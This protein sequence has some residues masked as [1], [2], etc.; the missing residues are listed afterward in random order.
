M[1]V[2]PG[3]VKKE[4][5]AFKN[6]KF[7]NYLFGDDQ[8]S[9]MTHFSGADDDATDEGPEDVFQVP[10]KTG[11]QKCLSDAKEIWSKHCTN[12][13]LPGKLQ[14]AVRCKASWRHDFFEIAN[15]RDTMQT[16]FDEHKTR[17]FVRFAYDLGQQLNK[18][19]D[20]ATE[21]WKTFCAPKFT[22]PGEKFWSPSEDF[23]AGPDCLFDSTLLESTEVSKYSAAVQ[24]H[25]QELLKYKDHH[26]FFLPFA[27]I[28]KNG[29]FFDVSVDAVN[30]TG[31]QK[32]VFVPGKIEG[33]VAAKPLN[34]RYAELD[35]LV[36]QY[37][38]TKTIKGK[39]P[40]E[41]DYDSQ[42]PLTTEDC[43]DHLAPFRNIMSKV[44]TVPTLLEGYPQKTVDMVRL[45]IMSYGYE[46]INKALETSVMENPAAAEKS[47]T[48][49]Y[50]LVQA[51]VPNLFS[52]VL[53]LYSRYV[54]NLNGHNGQ[55]A[56]ERLIEA[57]EIMSTNGF[58]WHGLK[59]VTV[60]YEDVEKGKRTR[61]QLKQ[62][63]IA[64]N[65][66]DR[67]QRDQEQIAILAKIQHGTD[68]AFTN[69]HW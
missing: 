35:S 41:F 34:E 24:K 22:F 66:N 36:G 68:E 48:T 43:A 10:E 38:E 18:I 60:P 46:Y 56:I 44:E 20:T 6:T 26:P 47:A 21:S 53:E 52:N 32:F 33:A 19:Q 13:F 5:K 1:K 61:Y 29:Q 7:T 67:F 27:N 57:F 30:G 28:L 4:V 12:M 25:V 37:F 51:N 64:N 63:L 16:C 55:K 2:V 3:V 69:G 62:R 23:V 42:L 40:N 50:F 58:G 11:A 17:I 59:P 54:K 9:A 49:A 39:K 8:Y 14:R 45:A 65:A 15:D 31:G